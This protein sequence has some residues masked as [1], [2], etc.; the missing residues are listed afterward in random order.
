MT[1]ATS[2]LGALALA[3]GRHSMGETLSQALFRI[4]FVQT[5]KQ[6]SSSI[7]AR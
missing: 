5:S 6:A 2:V 4:A 7:A 3:V 1:S